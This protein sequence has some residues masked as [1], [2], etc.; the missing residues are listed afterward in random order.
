VGNYS[1]RDFPGLAPSN[2][3]FLEVRMQ[4][5]GG[6]PSLELTFSAEF[7]ANREQYREFR[8]FFSFVYCAM[9][10]ITLISQGLS[11]HRPRIVLRL[12][13]KDSGW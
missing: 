12:H 6:A 11:V 7:P 10:Y 3:K 8:I 2:T 5:S 9:F 4:E 1:A 13:E